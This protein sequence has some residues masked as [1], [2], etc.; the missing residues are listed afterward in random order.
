MK[1]RFVIL[2][3]LGALAV[4]VWA[5]LLH[6]PAPP[7]L[8]ANTRALIL[9][10]AF[11]AALETD[12]SNAI[13]SAV[14]QAIAAEASCILCPDTADSSDLRAL[15]RRAAREKIAVGL[16]TESDTPLPNSIPLAGRWTV[17]ENTYTP[18]EEGLPRFDQPDETGSFYA[19]WACGTLE[20]T[21]AAV[22]NG[23]S[24]TGLL[25]QLDSASPPDVS[26][27][28]P[29]GP[30]IHLPAAGYITS[31][32]TCWLSGT[33]DPSIPATLNNTPVSVNAGGF[34]G[35]ALPLT[36]GENTFTL[37]Q[38]GISSTLTV[39]RIPPTGGTV[40]GPFADNSIPA[41]EGA[42]VKITSS[43]AS[44]LANPSDASSI[45]QT[46]YAGACAPVLESRQV[47]VGPKLTYAYRTAGGWV[48]SA[49]C[50][51][52]NSGV[53]TATAVRRESTAREERLLFA[54]VSPAVLAERTD[55]SLTLT[56]AGTSYNGQLPAGGFGRNLAATE[57]GLVLT[58]HYSSGALWGWG[59]DYT[60]EGT[61]ITL[62]HPPQLSDDPTKP[63]GGL[64]VLLDP[65]HGGEDLGAIGPAGTDGACEKDL[66]LAAANAAA[67]RLRQMGASVLLTR[68]GDT[69][70]TLAQRSEQL[71]RTKPDIFVSVHHN[72]MPLNRDL[73]ETSGVECYSFY[74][75]GQALAKHLSAEVAA[76]TGRPNRGAKED[77][78]YVTRADLCPAVLL[79]VGFVPNPTEF[80]ACCHPATL[81][82]TGW[83]ISAGICRAVCQAGQ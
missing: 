30:A 31:A 58:F 32:D 21:V 13:R 37:T 51:L 25:A 2:C 67:A 44:L 66:N 16:I 83:A 55:T 7:A 61:A 82:R 5:L 8:A 26:L 3:A 71:R 36:E 18:R 33:A 68:T 45:L 22:W 14:Q 80:A 35:A 27:H 64:T 29:A 24:Y 54:G 1:R 12:A 4:S 75:S 69:F 47:Q 52:I 56:L 53:G 38:N 28:I 34:W 41:P 43:L 78:F 9:N 76:C 23:P 49:D 70:P 42:G 62:R 77:Y 74:P 72:S 57:E 40:E 79:E 81:H 48:R 39:T 11:A 60:P 10:N 17:Q 20:G 73:G 65:G 63:L 6:T 46:V 50:T 59:V 15:A 19:A